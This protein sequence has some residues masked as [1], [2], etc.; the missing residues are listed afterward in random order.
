MTKISDEAVERILSKSPHEDN[1]DVSISLQE[2]ES[3]G[4][5][6]SLRRQ[7]ERIVAYKRMLDE[8]ITFIN[9]HLTLAVPFTRENLYLICAYTGSGKSTIAANISYPLWQQGKKVLVISN[10]ESE[11]DVIY[12]ISC[13]H[14]GI[15]FNDYKKGLMPAAMMA[16][17]MALFKEIQQY[18]KVVDINFKEGLTTKVEGVINALESAKKGDYSCV[19]IDYFQRI[20][21]STKDKTKKTFNVLE[22]LTSYLVRYIKESAA[23][24]V[25]LA[26]LHSIGKRNNPDLDSRI[27]DYPAVIEGATVVLEAVPDFETKTTDFRIAKDRFG[28]QG[29]RIQCGFDHGR[30]VTI[31][32]TWM[33]KQR[34]TQ[35]KEVEEQLGDQVFGQGGQLAQLQDNKDEQGTVDK[36]VSDMQAEE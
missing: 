7:F 10:E 18:V 13:L 36:E 23:P 14:L 4:N 30:F 22:E 11:E 3:Q 19:L 33:A 25:L 35:L 6:E 15:N 21:F 5:K 29:K 27:K 17:V 8:K 26:Q 9:E 16:Q 1:S 34:A 28:S 2:I 31:D 24:V 12:R 20:K 32:E